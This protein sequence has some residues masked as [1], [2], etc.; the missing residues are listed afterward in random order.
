MKITAISPINSATPQSI[1]ELISKVSSGLVVLPGYAVNT[2]SVAAVRKV[3]SPGVF[4][5]LESADKQQAA[6]WLVSDEEETRMQPQIFADSPKV[7]ALRNL[8]AS[9]LERTFLIGG[10]RVSFILCG[11]INAF[12]PD[13]STK[14]GI[15]LPFD[16]LVNPTHTPMGRWNILGRKLAALSKDRVVVHVA[17]NT[18]GSRTLTTDARIYADGEQVGHRSENSDAAWLIYEV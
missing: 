16:V 15:E 17:N 11:E 13:G 9:F 14:S 12:Q 5:F 1:V 4:V 2:P 18:S 3:L 6:P 7:Q 8:E 10:H